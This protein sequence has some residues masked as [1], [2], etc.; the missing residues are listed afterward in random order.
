MTIFS[1]VLEL[2]SLICL[3]I[4]CRLLVCSSSE[5]F[6]VVVVVVFVILPFLGLLPQ[7]MDV[8][9]LGVKLGL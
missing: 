8:P 6:V 2:T 3:C 5:G 4:N 7:H 1:A 9:R